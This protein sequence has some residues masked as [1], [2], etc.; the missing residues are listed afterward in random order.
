[1]EP[2]DIFICHASEDKDSIVRTMVDLFNCEGITCW[3][4]ETEVQ[5]GDSI[6]DKVNEGLR[7]SSYVLVVF[8]MAFIEKEWPQRELNS[9]LSK[10]ASSGEVKVLP[11]IVGSEEERV[12][13]LS[14]YPLLS[15]KMY[16]VW[17]DN[18]Q[19]IVCA[20]KSRLKSGGDVG[21]FDQSRDIS[22]SNNI[23]IPM[24][25]IKKQFTQRDR[26]LFLRDAFGKVKKYFS[27]GLNE[28][29]KRQQDVEAD[30]LEVDNLRFVAT[31]YVRGEIA[32]RCKIWMGGLHSL[33]SILY[34]SGQCSIDND[35][36][37]NDMLSVSD[38]GRSLGLSPSGMWLGESYETEAN[39]FNGAKAAEYLW[40]KFT[41]DMR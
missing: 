25:E 23:A 16:L 2:R 22:V 18:H 6:T 30:F 7:I 1:M 21:T 27:D 17:N 14:K 40:R 4:D 8:T 32:C 15:D 41:D 20:L 24:P 35:N 38:D 11:L 39:S 5:W 37:F 29:E 34:Q 9:I 28:I 12:M 13:I 33:D 3:Y 26:D 31:I 36:S 19:K 10:E